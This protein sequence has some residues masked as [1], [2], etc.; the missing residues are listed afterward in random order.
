MTQTSKVLGNQRRGIQGNF[1]IDWS[2]VTWSDLR[3]PLYSGIAAALY[4][5]YVERMY[6]TTIPTS[7][8]AQ[9]KF[10]VD[11]FNG[12][13]NDFLSVRNLQEGILIHKAA[14][15]HPLENRV[16]RKNKLLWQ[17]SGSTCTS[18]LTISVVW[19]AYIHVV[20]AHL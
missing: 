17:W 9:A 1:S 11:K 4:L 19:Y 7:I 16:I 14:N 20:L 15:K 8:N 12:Q 6:A 3:K 18:F 10:W 2:S 5:Q 13:L